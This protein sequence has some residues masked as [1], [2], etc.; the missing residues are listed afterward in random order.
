M[1]VDLQLIEAMLRMALRAEEAV[2]EEEV[3]EDLVVVMDHNTG[4]V[5]EVCQ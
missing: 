3:E 5:E 2:Q 4:K 1:V